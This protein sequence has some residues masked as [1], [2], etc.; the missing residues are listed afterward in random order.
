MILFDTCTGRAGVL[1][2]PGVPGRAWVSLL[3]RVR[4]R[5]RTRAWRWASPTLDQQLGNSWATV[6]QQLGDSWATVV[7][8]P[9]GAPGERYISKIQTLQVTRNEERGTKDGERGMFQGI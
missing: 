1:D 3:F 5:R 6:G 4:T 2:A 7:F 9:A 8:S